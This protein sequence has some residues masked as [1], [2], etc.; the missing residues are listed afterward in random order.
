MLI[1]SISIIVFNIKVME[2]T[3]ID[4]SKGYKEAFL[5]IMAIDL[6]LI[7][8]LVVAI[9]LFHYIIGKEL[10]LKRLIS[11][12]IVIIACMLILLV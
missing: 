11:V 6:P 2:S 7:V 1:A 4:F 8:L 9:V 12:I 10:K 5:N 3:K